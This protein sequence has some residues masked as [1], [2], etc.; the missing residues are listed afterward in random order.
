MNRIE[1]FALAVVITAFLMGAYTYPLMPE[2]VA[3]HWNAE[4]I[5]DGFSD[6]NFALFFMP[7]MM[8]ALLGLFMLLPHIDPLRTNVL[9]FMGWYDLLKAALTLFLFYLYILTILFNLGYAFDM[10][11]ALIPAFAL[12][13]WFMGML[14]ENAKRNWFIG[15]RTPWTLSSDIVWQK[16]HE[17]GGKL[18]KACA[19]VCLIGVFFGKAMLFF[20]LV[21]VLLASGYLIAY[22]YFEY[23]KLGRKK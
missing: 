15:I 23:K 13:L 22:S 12:L 17:R 16:T 1:A 19:V 11:V 18:F 14:M 8:L 5:P 2:V 3:T 10:G 7:A 21:P 20:V 4:G 9:K 6:R